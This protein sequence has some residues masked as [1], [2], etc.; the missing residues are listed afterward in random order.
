MR[1]A[2]TLIELVSVLAIVCVMLTVALGAYISWGRTGSLDA[3]ANQLAAALDHAR[4][5]AITQR[6]NTQVICSNT[7]FPGRP[8]RGVYA[9]FIQRSETND[10]TDVVPA[11]PSGL[12][13]PDV[14][15]PAASASQITITFLPDGTCDPVTNLVVAASSTGSPLTP[16]IIQIQSWRLRVLPRGELP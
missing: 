4:E 9:L 1:K 3:A 7:N 10:V 2:F 12:L 14:W 6:L 8:N 15:M 5:L 11:A 13:P 16:R